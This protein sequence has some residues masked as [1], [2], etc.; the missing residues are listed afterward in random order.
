MKLWNN[1]HFSSH[2]FLQNLFAFS[3]STLDIAGM[4]SDNDDSD[5]DP[6]FV[7]PNSESDSETDSEPDESS[8]ALPRRLVRK[9]E[10]TLSQYQSALMRTQMWIQVN[11]FWLEV[12]KVVYANYSINMHSTIYI[13]VHMY[14][15]HI[16]ISLSFIWGRKLPNVFNISNVPGTYLSYLYLPV[17]FLKLFCWNLNPF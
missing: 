4:F 12:S 5:A 15:A 6:T 16:H 17:I 10:F 1:V 14:I 2:N 13:N 11:I 3:L 7:N 8:I 9:Y